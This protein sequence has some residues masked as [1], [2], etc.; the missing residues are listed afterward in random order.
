MP[1]SGGVA[2]ARLRRRRIVGAAISV[3]G[4]EIV[5]RHRV[6]RHVLL[7]VIS[8]DMLSGQADDQADRPAHEHRNDRAGEDGGRLK[9][10]GQ[11]DRNGRRESGERETSCDNPRWDG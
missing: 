7:D 9:P 8:H 1:Q 5:R 4:L 3:A 11:T 6:P 2:P 10:D